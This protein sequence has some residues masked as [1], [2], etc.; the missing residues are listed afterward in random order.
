MPLRATLLPLAALAAI[1]VTAAL[2]PARPDPDA[3]ALFEVA[4]E[5]PAPPVACDAV[6]TPVTRATQPVTPPRPAGVVVWPLAVG[7]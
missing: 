6:A 5:L 2:L 1:C 3:P 4:V 7:G